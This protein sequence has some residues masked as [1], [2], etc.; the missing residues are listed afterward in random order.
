MYPSPLLGVE[1]SVEYEFSISSGPAIAIILIAWIFSGIVLMNIAKK[2]GTPN[3]WMG[4]VPILN[5]VLMCQC[6]G[7]PGWWFILMC[8]PLVNIIIA[9]IVWM[10]IAENC[11]RPAW[12]GVVICLVPLVN[13]ILVLM[14]AFGAR[15]MTAPPVVPGVPRA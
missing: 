12:W 10:A 6:A 14:L 1:T 11:G 7:K 2:T 8:I 13:F 5:A 4:F 9:I 15:P 3:G